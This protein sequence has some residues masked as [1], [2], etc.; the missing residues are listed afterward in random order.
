[1]R[2]DDA[3]NG[4]RDPRVFTFD[5]AFQFRFNVSGLR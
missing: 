4:A 3:A 2:I 5:K 1:M